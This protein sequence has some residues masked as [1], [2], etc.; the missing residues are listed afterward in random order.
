[1]F[2]H[3][4]SFSVCLLVGPILVCF[5]FII[6]LLLLLLFLDVSMFSNERDKGVD[7]WGKEGG[8]G[9]GGRET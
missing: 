3:W 1:V 8:W 6:P 7:L 9:G 2:L 4:F 5:Y